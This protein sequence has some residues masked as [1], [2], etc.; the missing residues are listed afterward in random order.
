MAQSPKDKEAFEFV[1]GE[2]GDGT[3]RAARLFCSF[4]G[5]HLHIV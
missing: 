5:R 4:F 3:G 1:L 2:E